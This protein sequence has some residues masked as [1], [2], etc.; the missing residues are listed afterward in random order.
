MSLDEP[1]PPG[2]VA[3]RVFLL[4][5]LA[6]LGF[7]AYAH[8]FS[9][10][11]GEPASGHEPVNADKIGLLKPEEAPA[12]KAAATDAPICLEW[13]NFSGA[14]LERA[15]AALQKLALGDRLLRVAVEEPKKWWVMIPPQGSKAEADRKAAQLKGLGVTDYLVMQENSKWKYAI[16]LGLFSSEEAANKQLTSLRDKGVR[17]ARLEPRFSETGAAKFLLRDTNAEV[18]ARLVEIKLGF[19]GSHLKAVTCPAKAAGAS[20]PTP[21][22]AD[23]MAAAERKVV[24]EAAPKPGM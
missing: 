6:N 19:E 12:P 18:E 15:D 11:T 10:S 5:L 21:T 13:G 4:L 24:V 22:Q 1:S 8:Y 14:D 17:S 20:R 9:G 2:S 3:K 16:S 7:Y 23:G